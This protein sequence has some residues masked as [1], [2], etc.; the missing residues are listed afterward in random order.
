M[1]IAVFGGGCFWPI[2]QAFSTIEGV[3][4][5]R[6]GYMG[7]GTDDPTYDE[8]CAGGTGHIEVVEVEFDPAV[9]SYAELVRAFWTMHDPTSW[10]QQGNDVGEQYRSV[11]FAQEEQ[12]EVALAELERAADQFAEDIVT[13]IREAGTFWVAE[14]EH[15]GFADRHGL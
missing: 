10:D 11:V 14:D 3:Q 1:Q 7:G 15:Q 13:E 6:A 9:V 5:T 2:E 4:D 8:V 12:A